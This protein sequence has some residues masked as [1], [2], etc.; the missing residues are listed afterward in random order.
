MSDVFVLGNDAD[1]EE[2]SAQLPYGCLLDENDSN[3]EARSHLQAGEAAAACFAGS[4]A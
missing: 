2:P 3:Q 1:K 4:D